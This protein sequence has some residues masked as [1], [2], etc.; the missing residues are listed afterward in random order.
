MIESKVSPTIPI[1]QIGALIC[2]GDVLANNT[3]LYIHSYTIHDLYSGGT[4]YLFF[5]ISLWLRNN[6]V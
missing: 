2:A 6:S 3:I 5:L 1:W 4:S